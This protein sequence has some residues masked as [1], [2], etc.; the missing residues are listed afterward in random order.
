VENAASCRDR[1]SAEFKQKNIAKAVEW[2]ERAL[3][4][5]DFDEGT[6]HF[7][8]RPQYLQSYCFPSVFL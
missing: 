6:W 3:Y 5:V 2:Y 4:H 7:E 1:G 8:V